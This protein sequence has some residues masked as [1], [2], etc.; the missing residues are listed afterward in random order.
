MICS[1]CAGL[2]PAEIWFNEYR[3]RD[4]SRRVCWAGHDRVQAVR[5]GAHV[6]S[7]VGA[8]AVLRWRVVP[9]RPLTA[10]TEAAA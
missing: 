4:G 1:R 9:R 10:C 7:L 6:Q 5:A 2:G 3:M 8:L